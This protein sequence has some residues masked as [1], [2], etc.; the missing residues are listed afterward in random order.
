MLKHRTPTVKKL[1]ALAL[2]VCLAAVSLLAGCAKQPAAAAPAAPAPAQKSLTILYTNDVHCAVEGVIGYS[3]LAAY[4]KDLIAKGNEVLLVDCGDA[5]QG[6]PIG[7]FTKGKSIIDIMNY[8]GYDAM[9]IGN[10]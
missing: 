7:S 3:G 6:A 9:A 5:V 4:K 10:H 1:L 2:I 8:L